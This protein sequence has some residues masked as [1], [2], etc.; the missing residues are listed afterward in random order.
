MI[1]FESD[2]TLEY[3]DLEN[4]ISIFLFLQNKAKPIQSRIA[5]LISFKK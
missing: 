3:S 5:L 2:Y 1:S 4:L